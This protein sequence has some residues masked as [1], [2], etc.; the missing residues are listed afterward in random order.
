MEMAG[1]LDGDE[2]TNQHTLAPGCTR[3]VIR[4]RFGEFWQHTHTYKHPSAGLG[5]TKWHL[6]GYQSRIYDDD[7]LPR[8]KL[9]LMLYMGTLH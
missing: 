6:G 1:C 5:W 8:L 7:C 9:L 4:M 3:G 2:R